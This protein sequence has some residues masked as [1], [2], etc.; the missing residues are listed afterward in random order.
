MLADG[1]K[2][3][4]SALHLLADCV[5]VSEPALECASTEDGRGPSLMISDIDDFP[6]L[7]DGVGGGHADGDALIDG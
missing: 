2:V 4:I 7:M 3:G 1:L 5:N 6:R